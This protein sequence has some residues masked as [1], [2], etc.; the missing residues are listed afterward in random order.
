MIPHKPFG[1]MLDLASR[2]RFDNE[3]YQELAR[4]QDEY[5]W[6]WNASREQLEE[7]AKHMQ[8]LVNGADNGS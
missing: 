7:W 6:P 4:L 8:P 1:R 5:G 2:E 3:A